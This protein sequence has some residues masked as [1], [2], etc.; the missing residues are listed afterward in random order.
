MNK[1]TQ[2]KF[3]MNKA[4]IYLSFCLL[5]TAGT[6]GAQSNCFD[7]LVNNEALKAK[8]ISINDKFVILDFWHSACTPCLSSFVMNRKTISKLNTRKVLFISVSV[9]NSIEKMEKI[10]KK[11]KLTWL[12]INDKN[13]G[14]T[15]CFKID[16]YPTAILLNKNNEEL[17][18]S[19]SL[20]EI[21]NDSLIIHLSHSK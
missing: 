7:A 9:D 18:R 12:N 14:I 17:K 2:K 21:L 20:H 15:S 8:K 10:L 3:Y 19:Y 5:L 4:L 13:Q 16:G 6:L 11:Y 1:N